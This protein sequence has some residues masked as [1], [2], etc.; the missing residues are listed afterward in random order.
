M[1]L[2]PGQELESDPVA[3]GVTAAQPYAISLQMGP[4][5]R[6]TVWHRVSNQFNYVPGRVIT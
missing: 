4:N 6:M 3:I 5:Q 2:A 1:T